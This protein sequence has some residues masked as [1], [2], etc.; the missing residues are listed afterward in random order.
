Q[1]L[2]RQPGATGQNLYPGELVRR[3]RLTTHRPGATTPG[4]TPRAPTFPSV[5]MWSRARWPKNYGALATRAH[6]RA[7][8]TCWGRGSRLLVRF[9]GETEPV[10]IRPHLLRVLDS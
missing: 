2:G 10:S 5:P 3:E 1:P 7:Q 6:Q 9:E 8:V 4:A